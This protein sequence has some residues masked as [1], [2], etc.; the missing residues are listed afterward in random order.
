MSNG[1]AKRTI[2]IVIL[3]FLLLSLL[4]YFQGGSETEGNNEY[5]PE[6]VYDTESNK[7]FSPPQNLGDNYG[8]GQLPTVPADKLP[9]IPAD[10]LP[11]VDGNNGQNWG[12]SSLNAGNPDFSFSQPSAPDYTLPTTLPS[13]IGTTPSFSKTNKFSRPKITASVP[14][15]Q[16]PTKTNQPKNNSWF[17]FNGLNFTKLPA[18]SR[19][20]PQIQLNETI[21]F[22]VNLF[23]IKFNYQLTIRQFLFFVSIVFMF[24][25]VGFLPSALSRLDKDRFIKKTTMSFEIDKPATVIS[26]QQSEQEIK[27]KRERMKRLINFK[28]HLWVIVE[29]T[30]SNMD[31]YSPRELI[32][33]TYHKID[34]AF[35]KFT[36]LKREIG[37]T[38]LEHAQKH[39][40]KGEINNAALEDI[41]ETF[42]LAR[43]G[44]KEL[45]KQHVLQ[46]LNDLENLVIAKNDDLI[47]EVE[48]NETP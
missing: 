29:W 41:V 21:S 2:F 20:M 15:K 10:A 6:P 12:I 14:S 33:E 18:K 36:K 46:L 17:Q 13:G 39:F 45:T 22:N 25:A 40:E 24:F 30:K 1:N 27:R 32:I 19:Y 34:N 38:P 37:E 3:F 35:S 42:Y 5:E 43:Y 28:D 4:Y 7:P 11:N 26:P 48:I 31:L 44:K 23:G 8:Y 47:E 9:T 16:H